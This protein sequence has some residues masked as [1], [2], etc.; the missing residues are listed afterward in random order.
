MYHFYMQQSQVKEK[1][2]QAIVKADIKL[3]KKTK[4]QYNKHFKTVVHVKT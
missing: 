1:K 2:R 3:K 4:M